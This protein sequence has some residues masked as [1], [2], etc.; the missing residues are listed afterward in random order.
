MDGPKNY[1]KSITETTTS[2]ILPAE[3]EP[4]PLPSLGGNVGDKE[5][6]H[7]DMEYWL[8]YF[9]FAHRLELPILRDKVF[10]RRPFLLH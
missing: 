1:Q 4:N 9:S 3:A 2:K 7:L 5:Q 8:E 10:C 6:N